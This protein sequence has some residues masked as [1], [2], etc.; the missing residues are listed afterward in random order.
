MKVYLASYA[1]LDFDQFPDTYSELHYRKWIHTIIAQSK[2]QEKNGDAE[3]SERWFADKWNQKA[4]KANRGL[5]QHPNVFYDRIFSDG[6]NGYNAKAFF[7][8]FR[9]VGDFEVVEIDLSKRY[10]RYNQTQI[11]NSFYRYFK[12][13]DE[14]SYKS[15]SL[16]NWE[17]FC[18]RV[19]KELE[20]NLSEIEKYDRNL[21]QILNALP[22]ASR[23]NDH[24]RLFNS[25]VQM[26]KEVRKHARLGGKPIIEIDVANSHPLIIG[27][28]SLRDF[29]TALTD[30]KSDTRSS[31]KYP[32]LYQRRLPPHPSDPAVLPTHIIETP[33]S[34]KHPLS[35]S[36]LHRRPPR[37]LHQLL[38]NG[39]DFY[40]ELA[41]I[42]EGIYSNPTRDRAKDLT[43]QL[44]NQHLGGWLT[45][46]LPHEKHTSIDPKRLTVFE[47]WQDE[48][49]EAIHLMASLPNNN[50]LAQK[51]SEMIIDRAYK[52]LAEK[53][54]PVI[55][56][57]D[58]IATTPPHE[59]VVTA[60]IKEAYER[61]LGV[62]PETTLE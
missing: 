7:W 34:A 14:S 30:L 46:S 22:T 31:F 11:H 58:G 25:Y 23:H 37:N 43:N 26:A 48:Y 19:I 9:G 44:I 35:F 55:P 61:K 54:L 21:F 6:S 27:C 15:K 56:T 16:S 59:D 47:L 32:K 33:P 50:L 2:R 28:S 49:P 13:S 29:A 5:R 57:H 1:D 52:R 53:E 42:M 62:A 4:Y 24:N 3:I 51:E 40:E 18:L 20:F 8:G 45:Y 39:N 10:N 36:D 41:D 38:K 17:M 12:P 60:E